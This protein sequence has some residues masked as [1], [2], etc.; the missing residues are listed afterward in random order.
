MPRVRA[1]QDSTRT[2]IGEWTADLHKGIIY[3]VS[4]EVAATLVNTGLGVEVDKKAYDDPWYDS[5]SPSPPPD[6]SGTARR[7]LFDPRPMRSWLWVAASHRVRPG[8]FA[9]P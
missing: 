8:P 2:G 4:E 3:D 9:R 1:T 5:E 7:G 6:R